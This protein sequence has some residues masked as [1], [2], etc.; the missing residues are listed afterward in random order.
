VCEITETAIAADQ[1]LAQA[2]VRQL[3]E[4][5]VRVALDDFGTGYGGLSY[6][7][8]LRVE[9]VKIDVEFVR[10]LPED[11]ESQHVV[12]AIVNLA[13]GF[14]RKTVAEGVENEPTLQLLE[15][16]GVD[17]AQGFWIGRPAPLEHGVPSSR[18]SEP[19]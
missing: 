16:L 15:G 12:K 10:D 19:L 18:S 11:L 7:K 3:V 8:R 6:L 1:E 17:Y 14:G 4:L 2:F 9:L 13:Q 5:G